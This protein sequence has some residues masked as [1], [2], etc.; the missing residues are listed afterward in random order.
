MMDP[1][2][3]LVGAKAR[4][5]RRIFLE[6]LLI[7]GAVGTLAGGLVW[8]RRQGGPA[9][10]PQ[11]RQALMG[12]DLVEALPSPMAT[13][14][15]AV[16]PPETQPLNTPHP[17]AP[18]VV[19]VPA[20]LAA[21][22]AD[23]GADAQEAQ[24]P[25]DAAAQGS[26]KQVVHEI[27]SGDTLYGIAI[28]Y[29][30]TLDDLY[31]ANN[32]TDPTGFHVGDKL[33]IPNSGD[34]AAAAPAAAAAG[35]A[36]TAPTP[37]LSQP[38]PI[39]V[40]AQEVYRVQPGDS[41]DDVASKHNVS[42]KDLKAFNPGLGDG[43]ELKAGQELVIR[44][45]Q[46][47]TATALPDGT[48]IPAPG[49]PALAADAGADLLPALRLLSPGGEMTV[50]DE[51]LLLRWSSAGILPEGL[52]YVVSLRDITTALAKGPEALANLPPLEQD[53][54]ARRE[55][56]Y[57]NA[58]ALR[59]P[60]ELRPAL[61]AKRVIEWSVTVRQDGSKGLEGIRSDAAGRE[62]RRFTWQPG[63]AAEETE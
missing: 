55:W 15:A 54:D 19:E 11:Q 62:I 59:V 35:G 57:S 29:G 36:V 41:L 47:A 32:V 39:V 8:L 12:P 30:V 16:A 45:A 31:A 51:V 9:I 20:G 1:P 40:R 10:D 38:Q 60:P 56:V 4:G 2:E 17:E 50:A 44:P 3:L 5:P 14:A 28:D 42:S 37:D 46:L 13:Q 49:Q 6:S 43:A 24:D 25:P 18:P 26:A 58:T 22:A 21:P 27:K 7:V 61:G 48:A 63:A 34:A 23:P 53:P 33:I 52:Y